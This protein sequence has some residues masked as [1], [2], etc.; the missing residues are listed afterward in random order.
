MKHAVVLAHPN[1]ASFTHANAAAYETAVRALGHE[2]VRRD[3]YAADFDP[4]MPAHEIPGAPDYRIGE[5]VAAERA[6]V[7]EADVFAFFYPWWFNAPPAI[8]KGYVDRVMGPGFG[9]APGPSGVQPLLAGR[10]LVSFTTSGAPDAWVAQTGALET[11]K[12]GFDAHLAGVLGLSVADHVHIGGVVANMTP[13]A[14]EALLAET[15]DAARRLF[16]DASV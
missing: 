11:L 2:T 9:Y 8:L 5:E 10:R 6:L 14:A 3:L 1:P 7:A 15:A 13:E 12:R 4:R 16:G